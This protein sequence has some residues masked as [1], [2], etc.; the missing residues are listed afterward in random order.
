MLLCLHFQL[1]LTHVQ[2]NS[3]SLIL[4]QVSVKTLPIFGCGGG[5]GWAEGQCLIQPLLRTE[6][7][8]LQCLV[9]TQC[10][11]LPLI[12]FHRLLFFISSINFW[13]DCCIYLDRAILQ[14]VGF[15]PPP[16]SARQKLQFWINRRETSRLLLSNGS[17]NQD[18]GGW[19]Q[20]DRWGIY[21]YQQQQQPQ[22]HLLTSTQSWLW[23]SG[24]KNCC[25]KLTEI[26]SHH[27]EKMTGSEGGRLKG[28]KLT[29]HSP[30]NSLGVFNIKKY[31][32]VMNHWTGC[33]CV[34]E[35]FI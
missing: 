4:G 22:A 7:A 11:L 33:C 28:V 27:L 34:T 20:V 35:I 18:V 26:L 25:W 19:L 3:R 24:E 15:S 17:V 30:H 9:N 21:H 13:H 5:T 16:I 12:W 23:F 8:Q 14:V 31:E 1:A 32:F 29:P 2:Q 6:V 10:F